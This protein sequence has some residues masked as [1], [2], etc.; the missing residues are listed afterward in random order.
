MRFN[1]HFALRYATGKMPVPQKFKS[2]A[3]RASCPPQ[4]SLL[5][6][7]QHFSLHK[8]WRI[9]SIAL[10]SLTLLISCFLSLQSPPSRAAQKPRKLAFTALW[11]RGSEVRNSLFKDKNIYKMNA[12]GSGMA[13]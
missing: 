1:L 13:K 8:L 4:N 10:F 7:L 11:R 12:D 9:S 3:G 6:M 2:I 5:Q